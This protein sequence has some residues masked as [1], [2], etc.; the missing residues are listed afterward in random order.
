MQ[1]KRL[2]WSKRSQ[3]HV[4]SIYDYIAGDNT[5]AAQAVMNELRT[6]ARG[7]CGFPLMGHI[8]RR[9]GVREL[10]LK[11]YPYTLFYRVK[12]NSIVIVAVLR[13]SQNR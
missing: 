4:E 5:R 8:G 3:R 11:K 1:K 13:D 6:A 10:V 7:L 12:S 9:E 2:D